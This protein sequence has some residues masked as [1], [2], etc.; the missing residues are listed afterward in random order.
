MSNPTEN[1]LPAHEINVRDKA[2]T[3]TKTTTATSNTDRPHE[4][5]LRGLALKN[6]FCSPWK[7]LKVKVKVKAS[8]S[9]SKSLM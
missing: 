7:K 2:T 5:L 4:V 1:T 3:T 6:T 8:K 9:K